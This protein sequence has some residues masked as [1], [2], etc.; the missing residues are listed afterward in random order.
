[1][2]HIENRTFDEIKIGD[3]ASL[4][5]TLTRDDINLFAVMSGD[6]NPAQKGDLVAFR[7]HGRWRSGPQRTDPTS[8]P[9][10]P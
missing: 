6:V 8:T 7:R 5:R 1:M 10:S 2:E 9:V 4:V 3:P